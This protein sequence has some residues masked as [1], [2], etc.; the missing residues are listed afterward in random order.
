LIKNK[1]ISSIFTSLV[2]EKDEQ[3]IRF[4]E[5]SIGSAIPDRLINFLLEWFISKSCI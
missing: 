5:I 1:L 2:D 3:E 4:G